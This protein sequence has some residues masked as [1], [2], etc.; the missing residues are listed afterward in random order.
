M[1]TLDDEH[2]FSN[3]HAAVRPS[4]TR[5]SQLSSMPLQISVVGDRAEQADHEPLVHV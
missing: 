5:P 1:N 3:V 4:S 2:R